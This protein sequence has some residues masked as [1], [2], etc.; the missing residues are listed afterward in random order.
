M[1]RRDFIAGLGGT[2][3]TSVSWP[4]GARAQERVR[5]IG[6]LLVLTPLA[7]LSL[8]EREHGRTIPLGDIGSSLRV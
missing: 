7:S 8:V 5:R 1:K 3:A 2:A 4:R 6:V